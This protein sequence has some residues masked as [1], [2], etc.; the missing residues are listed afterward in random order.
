MSPQPS[1]TPMGSIPGIPERTQQRLQQ[2]FDTQAHLEAVWLF[3]SRAM[4]RHR[5]GSDIDLCLEGREL[6]HRDRLRLMAAI[7]ELL[8]PWQVDVALRREIS[9]DLEAHVKRVGRCL[10]RRS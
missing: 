2:V 1:T 9:A 3:G 7:D 4:G 5:E 10:W 8:L 6:S